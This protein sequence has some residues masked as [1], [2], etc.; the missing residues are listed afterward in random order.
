ML[1]SHDYDTPGSYAMAP[2]LTTVGLST[3]SNR[4]SDTTGVLSRSYQYDAAGNVTSWGAVTFAY[5]NANRMKSSTQGGVTSSYVYN[6]L[7]QRIGKTS[8]GVTTLFVYDEAGHLIGEYTGAGALI[9]ETVYLGDIPVVTL[10]PKAGG[11]VDIYYVHA[12][13]LNTPRRISRPAD[14]IIVWRWNSDPFGAALALQDPDG[15]SQTFT[16]NLRFPGQYFD[17]ESGLSYNYFRDYDSAIGRYV[18][19]DPVGLAGGSYS[20]YT[21]VRDN[22]IAN[23]DPLGL[24]SCDGRW[25][26]WGEL[27]PTLPGPGWT[28]SPG[29]CFCYWMCRPCRGGIAWSGNI[30]SLPNTKGVVLVDYSGRNPPNTGLSGLRPTPNGPARGQS[31]AAGGAYTCLCKKPSEETKGPGCDKCYPNSN[32]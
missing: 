27:I 1:Q 24:A 9:E 2:G 13:H 10:R 23:N 6:A 25:E 19:S 16:Y 17:A 20:T 5:N 28:L 26:K 31:G 14:N 11:G 30:Y 21:Y 18:E 12:D 8:G 29:V 15:D 3:T 22:P 7:G 4:V 32:F